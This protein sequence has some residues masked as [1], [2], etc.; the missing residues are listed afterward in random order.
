MTEKLNLPTLAECKEKGLVKWEIAEKFYN[1]IAFDYAVPNSCER[2]WREIM[3]RE[4]F[5]VLASGL[6][7]L[8]PAHPDPDWLFGKP[9][10]LFKEAEEWTNIYMQKL[11]A[12]SNE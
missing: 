11:E 6:V 9:G 4:S 7:W 8:Y 3:P 2:A 5:Y 12:L 10:P 1:D